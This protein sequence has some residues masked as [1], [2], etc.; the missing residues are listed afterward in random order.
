[1]FKNSNSNIKPVYILNMK[2]E[3]SVESAVKRLSEDGW[4]IMPNTFKVDLPTRRL[5]SNDYKAY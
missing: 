5:I 3:E 1:M 4:S 2:E